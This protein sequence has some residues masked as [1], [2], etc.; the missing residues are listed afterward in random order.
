M[1]MLA[2]LMLSV[3]A[4]AADVKQ[5]GAVGDGVADDTKA[6]LKAAADCKSKLKAIQPKGGSFQGSCPELYFPAGKYKISQTITL[7]PYQ[8]VRGEDAILVQSA[9]KAILDFVGGYQNRVTGMQFVG[10]TRQIQYSN[11][12]VDSSFLTLRDCSFQSWSEYAVWA[13]GTVDDL[14][15][16]ATL[17]V[18]RCRFDG[19]RAIYTHCDTTQVSDCEAHFRGASVPNGAAWICNKGY[20]R[21]N[22][23]PYSYGGALGLN[24]LTLVPCPPL[25][26]MEDGSAPKTI[27]AYWIDNGGTVV[28]ERVRFSGEG[29]GIPVVLQRAPINTRNPWKGSKVVLNACQVSCGQDADGMAGVV[30]LKGGFP[31]HL[32]I[33]SCDSLVSNHIPVIRVAEGYDLGA[34]VAAIPVP[35]L[36]MYSIILQG[37]QLYVDQPIPIPLL[38][39]V[40]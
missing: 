38:P 32:R 5:F 30:T 34:D 21:P 14:H 12:N 39:F 37:N 4:L 9:D 7:C 20:I 31:Q 29:G 8:A 10:G 26:P 36:P 33:T 17:S 6:I 16:S 40:K 19:G 24:N 11:A 3:T 2:F 25:T 27:N 22:G 28:C 18:S 23:Q 15:L 35:S 1:R 13:E